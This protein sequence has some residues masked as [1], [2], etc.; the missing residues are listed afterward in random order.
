M[1]REKIHLP[2][3][4]EYLSILDE[5]GKLDKALEPD[6]SKEFLL[7]LQRAMLLGRRFDERMLKL[8]RQ[9][10]IGT[11]ALIRGQEASQIGAV[12]PLR[13]TDWIVPAFRE[14][15]AEIY[16]G[17]SMENILLYYGGYNQASKIEEDVLSMPVAIPVGTQIPHAVGI[18]YSLNYQGKDDVAMVFFGD[19]ATSQ[20]DFHEALHFAAIFQTPTIFFC[21][22]NQWAISLPR[23]KQNLAETLAQEGIGHGIPGIQVDGNDILAVWVATSEAVERARK[24]GG[25][26][27]VESITYRLS[28]H[29]T[30]DDPTRYR[31][32]EE[33]KMW[34]KRDPIP[35][36]QKY[37]LEKGVL[38]DK[39]L[40]DVEE[41]IEAEIKSVVESA[42]KKMKE[43]DKE[44]LVMF[45]HLFAEM[46]P[47]LQEQ[48]EE[49]VRELSGKKEDSHE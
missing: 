6:L 46:P 35:R 12:A 48:R 11:F 49:L 37:L 44:P 42:E 19:G 13:K 32:E 39:T 3:E 38:T 31:S 33:V 18:G 34:E 4:V 7:K 17:K 36:F 1:P 21:Q 26:T 16:R 15:A 20:G 47:Y 9:G 27:L 8:Q 41:D 25:P 5:D 28:L 10:R 45:E 2:L 29:T 23:S 24:G 43:L 14:T 40:A 22:N 30:A